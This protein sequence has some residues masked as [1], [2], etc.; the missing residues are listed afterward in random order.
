MPP[1]KVGDRRILHWTIPD[2]A[3]DDLLWETMSPNVHVLHLTRE[4]AIEIRR[5]WRE[6]KKRDRRHRWE[7]DVYMTG[8][9]RN[10]VLPNG[11][12][13]G[14]QVYIQHIYGPSWNERVEAER[15]NGQA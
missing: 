12:L 10:C 4:D 9:Y 15:I 5:Q 2:D 3:A 14:Y 6:L 8:Q 1:H 13:V 7:V 11:L